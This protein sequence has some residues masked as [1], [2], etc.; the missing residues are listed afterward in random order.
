MPLHFSLSFSPFFSPSWFVKKIMMI[1]YR[2]QLLESF[3]TYVNSTKLDDFLFLLK[4][5]GQISIVGKKKR[6][7]IRNVGGIFRWWVTNWRAKIF[8]N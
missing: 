8:D 3:L 1:I 7:E 2:F 5:A 6:K 4:N